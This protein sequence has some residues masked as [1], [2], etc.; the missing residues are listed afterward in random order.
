MPM[1]DHLAEWTQDRGTLC[2]PSA[3]GKVPS[4]FCTYSFHSHDALDISLSVLMQHAQQ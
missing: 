2:R 4:L 1:K 3:I